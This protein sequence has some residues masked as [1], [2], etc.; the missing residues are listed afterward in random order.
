MALRRNLSQQ[1][2]AIRGGIS[3]RTPM[4]HSAAIAPRR[5]VSNDAIDM[6]E[7]EPEV[8]EPE[9]TVATSVSEGEGVSPLGGYSYSP[10]TPA[11]AR[12]DDLLAPDIPGIAANRALNAAARM[13]LSSYAG[14]PASQ[15]PKV[16]LQS[17]VPSSP[18]A[19]ALMMLG[20]LKDAFGKARTREAYRGLTDQV[21]TED[22]SRFNR[23]REFAKASDAMAYNNTGGV[24]GDYTVSEKAR[25]QLA[26]ME[27]MEAIER[28]R[29]AL[30]QLGSFLGFND[31]KTVVGPITQP[32][33]ELASRVTSDSKG[34]DSQSWADDWAKN[35]SHELQGELKALGILGTRQFTE[36]PEDYYSDMRG[37]D[38]GGSAGSGGGRASRD[39][40][41]AGRNDA[42]GLGGFGMW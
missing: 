5:I 18:V 20:G 7:T 12:L 31:K 11:D 39:Q 15:L 4:Y 32:N 1:G 28:T 36:L 27:N 22:L 26:N 16:G 23:T 33:E 10:K 19:P 37:R 24:P 38:S 42:S 21:G 34:M 17:F 25:R 8:F 29:S 30:P 2:T 40:D 6:V 35:L 41:T 13:G 3:A 9:D 14:V